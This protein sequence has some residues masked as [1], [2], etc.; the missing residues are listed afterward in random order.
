[1]DHNGMWSVCFPQP[2]SEGQF[3]TSVLTQI[4]WRRLLLGHGDEVVF[5]KHVPFPNFWDYKMRDTVKPCKQE[6]RK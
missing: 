4:G 5:P 6:H 3:P 2:G 1:M